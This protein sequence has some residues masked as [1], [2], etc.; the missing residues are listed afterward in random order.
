MDAPFPRARPF[1]TEFGDSLWAVPLPT[2]E[3][4]PFGGS[5]PRESDG[6]LMVFRYGPRAGEEEIT[7]ALSAVHSY[8]KASGVAIC[9]HYSAFDMSRLATLVEEA[10]CRIRAFAPPGPRSRP[11]ALALRLA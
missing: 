3:V 11:S 1:T 10:L 6:V 4:A 2:G 9:V 5:A 8:A 7:Y